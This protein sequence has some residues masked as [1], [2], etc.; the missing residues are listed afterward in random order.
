[1]V[2]MKYSYMP[3]LCTQPVKSCGHFNPIP[4]CSQRNSDQSPLLV[5]SLLTNLAALAVIIVYTFQQYF[6][7][8]LVGP[9]SQNINK[10]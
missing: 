7:T 8:N 6:L 9:I 4:A 3:S 1:M 10:L 2:H 5:Q